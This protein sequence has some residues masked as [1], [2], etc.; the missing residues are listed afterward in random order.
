MCQ[1]DAAQSKAPKP[2][3]GT[4]MVAHRLEQR[5]LN[6]LIK[7]EERL[8]KQIAELEAELA[9]LVCDTFSDSYFT[10]YIY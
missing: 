7:Q 2:T 9:E 5:R 4:T 1:V 6:S 10:E 8:E 3:A